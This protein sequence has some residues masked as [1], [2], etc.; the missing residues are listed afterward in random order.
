M[1]T[2]LKRPLK[3]R[4]LFLR[5]GFVIALL[6]VFLA[7]Q[8]KTHYEPAKPRYQPPIE[9]IMPMQP[10]SIK[11]EKKKIPKAKPQ[12]HKAEPIDPFS[13]ITEVDHTIKKTEKVV[14]SN[15]KFTFEIDSSVFENEGPVEHE[16]PKPKPKP[17]PRHGA[18]Y[19]PRFPGGP[20]AI[21]AFIREHIHYPD[22]ER[23]MGIEGTVHVRFVVDQFGKVTQVEAAKGP[24][25]AMRKEAERVVKMLP[26]W[27]PG[28]HNGRPVPV[29]HALPIRFQLSE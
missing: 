4:G 14:E 28:R 9:D 27:E 19:M 22:D 11:E 13:K 7:F 21:T 29:Y 24:T 3:H 23:R 20:T 6:L 2:I 25:K 8:W 17:E 18:K 1:K 10:V 26:K 12:N 5:V 16:M 15:E